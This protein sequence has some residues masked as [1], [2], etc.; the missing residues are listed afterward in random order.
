MI[1][2]TIILWHLTMPWCSTRW[3]V[4]VSHDGL[5]RTYAPSP[6][7]LRRIGRLLKGSRPTIW[8]HDQAHEAWYGLGGD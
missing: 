6:S 4:S 2:R 7:S 8:R 3:H 1:K 5:A